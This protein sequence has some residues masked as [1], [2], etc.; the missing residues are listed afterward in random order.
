MHNVNWKIVIFLYTIMLITNIIPMTKASLVPR[1][2]HSRSH[3]SFLRLE[4]IQQGREDSDK[5]QNSAQIS[6]PL[7]PGNGAYLDRAVAILVSSDT[8]G[9]PQARNFVAA[10][11][12]DPRNSYGRHLLAEHSEQHFSPWE[13]RV[14]RDVSVAQ[15]SVVYGVKL[16]TPAIFGFAVQALGQGHGAIHFENSRQ[17]V[18]IVKARELK[19]STSLCSGAYCENHTGRRIIQSWSPDAIL[20]QELID[21][22]SVRRITYEKVIEV[23]NTYGFQTPSAPEIDKFLSCTCRKIGEGEKFEDAIRN[24]GEGFQCGH[25]IIVATLAK[26]QLTQRPVFPSEEREARRYFGQKNWLTS[27]ESTDEPFLKAHLAIYI[28]LDRNGFFVTTS[29]SSSGTMYPIPKSEVH[30]Y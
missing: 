8:R 15:H 11:I 5:I 25:D 13:R 10:V 27:L 2:S 20:K 14:K 1:V 3:E 12:N 4:L 26:L 17:F 28:N 18:Y 23:A 22:Y 6:R 24:N 29:R 21:R 7:T 9:T 16:P 19:I 30:R